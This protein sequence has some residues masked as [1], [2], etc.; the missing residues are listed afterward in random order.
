LVSIAAAHGGLAIVITERN[1]G[2]LEDLL[3][4]VEKEK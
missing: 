4:S 3:S 1:L 2:E